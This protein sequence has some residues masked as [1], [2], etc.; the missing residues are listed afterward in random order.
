[1]AT[2]VFHPL[3]FSSIVGVDNVVVRPPGNPALL[4]YEPKVLLRIAGMI[5]YI[6]NTKLGLLKAE[7]EMKK[8]AIELTKLIKKEYHLK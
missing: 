4:T 5:S 3:Q 7:V 2:E 8:D 6:T 1:M